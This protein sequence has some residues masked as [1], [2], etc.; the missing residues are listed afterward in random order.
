[1]AKAPKKTT[2]KKAATTNDTPAA[3]EANTG[4]APAPLTPA[5]EREALNKQFAEA[6]EKGQAQIINDTQ[7]GLQIRGY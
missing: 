1:M 2:A 3:T 6:D 5:Q 4:Q 7:V